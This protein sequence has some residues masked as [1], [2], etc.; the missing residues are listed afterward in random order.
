MIRH[1]GL[2]QLALGSGVLGLS[3]MVLPVALCMTVL[4]RNAAK[5]RSLTTASDTGNYNLQNISVLYVAVN[6]LGC[7]LLCAHCK[8]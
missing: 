3:V 1:N 4:V 2:L 7:S 6:S 5:K 8:Y